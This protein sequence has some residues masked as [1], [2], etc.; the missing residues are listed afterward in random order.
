ME[1]TIKI[2]GYLRVSK[3]IAY[4][5]YAWVYF[6]VI[7]LGL[8]VFLLIFSANPA[9]P[10]VRFIYRTAADYL[11]PFRQIFPPHPVTQTGYLD[12][13][14]VFAIIIYLLLGWGFS[15]L[16]HYIQLKIDEFKAAAAAQAAR[17]TPTPKPAK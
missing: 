13:A 12:V 9:T 3:V 1:T 2:P 6:G 7:V 11:E 4:I 8:Q 10:F 5:M 14:A 17:P 16:I 15:A